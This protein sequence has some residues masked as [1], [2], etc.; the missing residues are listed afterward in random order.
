MIIFHEY[1]LF[2]FDKKWNDLT[3]YIDFEYLVSLLDIGDIEHTIFDNKITKE[4]VINFLKENKPKIYLF[5]REL[6]EDY[7]GDYINDLADSFPNTLF[8]F[9][10]METYMFINNRRGFKHKNCIV[11]SN[12]FENYKIDRK[13]HHNYYA[14][15]A[16]TQKHWKYIHKLWEM[17]SE[18]KRFKK[19]H[20]F[21]GIHKPHRLLTY[22]MMKRNN[23]LEEGFFSYLDY[24][25]M[26]H[27][28]DV[29]ENMVNFFGFKS[30]QEYTD[31]V[32]NFEIPYLCDT[33]ESTPNVFVA[34][35][36]PPQYTLQSYIGITTETFFFDDHDK[37]STSE[38]SWKSFLGFNIPLILGQRNTYEFL[39][40]YKFDL[41]ED[42]FDVKPQNNSDEMLIQFEKNLK[43]IKKIKLEELHEFYLKNRNRIRENYLQ[44]ENVSNESIYNINRI[45][46][47]AYTQ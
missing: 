23:L 42:F 43:K 33:N 39:K 25:N 10:D 27:R 5:N 4:W 34:W 7:D 17:T 44:L 26:V 24:M 1:K 47:E 8:I 45:C 35:A 37:V 29:V 22:D 12:S 32:S 18:L 46:K 31:Y 13:Y 20:F 2:D 3:Q 19:Y 15:N 16:G 40:D 28:D 9:H 14:L 30:K 21:N 41:F 36:Y 6:V 38:K 11:I